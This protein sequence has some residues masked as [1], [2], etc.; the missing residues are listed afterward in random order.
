MLVTRL[1]MPAVD[2]N[3]EEGQMGNP[4]PALLS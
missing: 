1:H 3:T 4:E 2:K